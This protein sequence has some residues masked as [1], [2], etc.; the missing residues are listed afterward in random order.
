MR[1]GGCISRRSSS[2]SGA[3]PLGS[4][5]RF[6]LFLTAFTLAAA[7]L[8]ELGDGGLTVTL[9]F[10]KLFVYASFLAA[11]LSLGTLGLLAKRDPFKITSFDTSRKTPTYLL[12]LLNKKMGHYSAPQ[13]E[14]SQ[15]RRVVVS[16]NVDKALQEVFDYS[17]RD[18]VL[19]WYG[20]RSRDQGQLYLLLQQD[21]WTVVRQLRGRLAGVDVVRLLCGDV[22]RA[23]HSHF[24]DLRAAGTGQEEP[25]R[26]FPLH[27]CLRS[28]NDE[29]R[30]MRSCVHLLLLC[31]GPAHHTCSL[32]AALADIL[33]TKVLCPLVEQLSDPDYINRTLLT[34]LEQRE[35]LSERHR[36]AYTYAPSYED[37]IKL[38]GSS[39]DIQFLKQLR[40]QIVVEIVQATTISSL[41]QLKKQRD[42]RGKETAAMK[43]DLLRARNVKRYINQLTVA[44]RCCE[45]R[46]RLLGG[47]DYELHE[48]GLT[49]ELD[50]MRGQKILQFEE[51]M[52][53]PMYRQQFHIYMERMDKRALI[54]F[55]EQVEMLKT[56]SKS[57]VPQQVGDIYQKYFVESKEIPVEKALYKELQQT[58]VGNRGT[59]VIHRIQGDVYESLRERYYPS[60]LVSD[61]C[62]RLL[63][64]QE[65]HD[66]TQSSFE[67]NDE[68]VCDTGEELLDGLSEQVSYATSKLQ[69]LHS[70]LEYKMQAL[71]S[72]QNSPKPDKK[73]VCQLMEEI[74][75]MEKVQSELQQHVSR[76][77]W[78]CE[79]LGRWRAIISSGELVEEN[80]DQVPCFSLTVSLM[81]ADEA[82]GNHWVVSRKLNDFQILHRKLTECFPSLKKV[83]LP[84]LSKLP[85]KSIDLKFLEKSKGQLN[86]FLEKML[87]DERLCQSELLYAFLS[88]SPEH[89]KVI[90]IQNKTTF[91]LASFLERLPGDLFSHQETN[92]WQDE[93]DDDNDFGCG[94]EVAEP[95]F[96]LIGEIFELRGMFKWV[97]KT[98]IALV[99]VTFGRTI[100]KQIRDTASWMF[101]EQMLTC[102]INLFRDAFWPDG[103]LA[104]PEAS[105]SDQERQE[106][107]ERARQKLLDNIPEA[108]QN[109]VGQQNARHGIIKI[110]N[111]LQEANANKHLL[112]VLLQIVLRELCPEL[113]TEADQV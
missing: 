95:C 99:Q 77:D 39:S 29:L 40:Y 71:G 1:P 35:Q 33:T 57:E 13:S 69:Q 27:P 61:L 110:F 81:E 51:I 24:C 6:F 108:L 84:S 65:Q 67:D 53:S 17:Y 86:A 88:P 93:T 70:K 10:L 58:L 36:K 50:G 7:V 2:A 52:S 113:G 102:Y 75:A 100:N 44:K 59:G 96:M 34:Q 38:I 31:L 45:A 46:I 18:Y 25:P 32:R 62:E 20:S 79:N 56:V 5:P 72:I 109:L 49:D 74:A 28:P 68:M 82:D 112:Y 106:T 22:V 92:T 80:G 105:R 94:D 37:F 103:K 64:P 76:T 21:F 111:A 42:S 16:L 107:K 4:P 91:S 30:F 3:A 83:Q 12:D 101:S 41:P 14:P 87:A 47:P 98:L 90:D 11:C 66:S 8:F 54:S 73:I 60:F 9:L 78:W 23:L 85:F 15:A 26:P 104:E 55:W 48:D 43:A 97:R 19:S 63:Q 89:L